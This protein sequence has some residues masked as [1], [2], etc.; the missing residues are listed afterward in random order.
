[1]EPLE[2]DDKGN[3][4]T[5]CTKP[6]ADERESARS[7]RKAVNRSEDKWKGEEEEEKQPEEEGSVQ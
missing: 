5:D 6:D 3:V 4:T 1:M 7:K 2:E